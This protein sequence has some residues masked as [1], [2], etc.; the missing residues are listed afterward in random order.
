MNLD[1]GGN[2]DIAYLNVSA[3]PAIFEG[4]G[5]AD[6]QYDMY[7]HMRGQVLFND[8]T[9]TSAKLSAR[10]G[11]KPKSTKTTTQQQEQGQAESSATPDEAW[12][13]YHPATNLLW[14]HFILYQLMTVIEPPTSLASGQDFELA[15]KLYERLTLLNEQKMTMECLKEKEWSSTSDLVAWAVQEGWLDEEDV[16]GAGCGGQESQ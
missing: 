16:M 10:R 1:P 7:R 6:Y 15:T 2:E 11:R 5:E 3:D 13:A 8:P 12:R 4:D 9:M 14:L